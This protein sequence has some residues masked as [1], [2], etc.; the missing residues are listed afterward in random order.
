MAFR[1]DDLRRFRFDE[2]Y[3]LY[4]EEVDLMR[5]LQRAGREMI[6]VPAARVR[7]AWGRSAAK[8]PESGSMFELSRRRFQRRWFGRLGEAALRW[9]APGTA[10][11]CEAPEL[12]GRIITLPTAGEYLIELADDRDFV[13]A[14]GRFASGGSVELPLELLRSSPLG[15]LCCRVTDLNTRKTLQQ[16]TLRRT[17]SPS[18]RGSG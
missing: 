17:P 9:S 7:H 12:S 1:A 2:R 3:P 14:A 10:P 11:Q 4:F 15:E 5:R 16:W 18:G 8:N 13:M 6:H